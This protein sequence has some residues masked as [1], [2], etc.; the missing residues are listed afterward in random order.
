MTDYRRTNCYPVSFQL[1]DSCVQPNHL[2]GLSV[3]WHNLFDPNDHDV[4][5]G[6]YF[7]NTSTARLTGQG[8]ASWM[9]S[10]YIPVTPGLTYCFSG[11]ATVRTFDAD[12]NFVKKGWTAL[13]NTSNNTTLRLYQFQEGISYIRFSSKT[14]GAVD[15]ADYIQHYAMM[16]QWTGE[17]YAYNA[18]HTEYDII[19]TEEQWNDWVRSAVKQGV[20]S[21][22]QL[23]NISAFHW[24]RINPAEVQPGTLSDSTGDYQYKA[25]TELA[26]YRVSG[27]TAVEP[28]TQYITQE[29]VF[30]YDAD[31][32]FLG[33]VSP[34]NGHTT[35]LPSTAYIR[36]S[37][38]STDANPTF[39]LLV[40][41]YGRNTLSTESGVS[42]TECIPTFSTEMLRD[43]FKAYLGVPLPF[44]DKKICFLSD[45]VMADSTMC[46]TIC[47]ALHAICHQNTATVGAGFAYDSSNTAATAYEQ[48]QALV[49]AQVSPDYI[50]ILLGANDQHNARTLGSFVAS[51]TSSD[52]DL[53]TFYGG[54]QSCIHYLQNQYPNAILQLGFTPGT[55]FELP[56]DNVYLSAM[57]EV[58]R[59]YGISYL[60]TRLCGI[61][62]LSGAYTECYGENELLTEAGKVRVGKQFVRNMMGYT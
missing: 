9:T 28:D 47:S 32:T 60:D 33:K 51:S 4:K 36:Q 35:T 3:H 5:S 6:W 11:N 62:P 14:D 44:A 15:N 40:Q 10:G 53:N 20:L 19:A 46:N 52:F 7:Y 17:F 1:T 16:Y 13:Y 45:D 54:L 29:S 26:Y 50:F 57:R 30:C 42:Y 22:D 38:T 23:P 61:T 21:Y 55:G 43:A 12:K 48:A 37:I 49:A 25:D 24:N 34:E 59:R 56:D 27:F 31:Y 8:T 18:Y 39:S 2:H 41:R 58:A